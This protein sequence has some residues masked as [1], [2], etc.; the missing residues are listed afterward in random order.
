MG[1]AM[2]DLTNPIFS[3]AD[4]AREHLEKLYWPNGPVC[5]HCGNADATRIHKLAGKSTRPGLLWCNECDKP[6]SVTIGTVMEDSHIPLNKWVLAFHLMNS[7]KKGNSAHQLMRTLASAHYK[8][9]WFIAH[10]VR[11]AMADI[12]PNANDGP[13]GGK[14]KVVEVDETVVGGKSKNRAYRKPAPKKSG[15]NAR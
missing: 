4:K 9:A 13:L 8:S 5:R 10:R 11:E 1:N 3:D 12:D 14:D 6:F 7:S 2:C 15:C